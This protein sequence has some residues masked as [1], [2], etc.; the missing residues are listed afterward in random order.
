V[1][2]SGL[3]RS[4]RSA[5]FCARLFICISAVGCAPASSTSAAAVACAPPP[6]YSEPSETRSRAQEI[7]PVSLRVPRPAQAP[8]ATEV[9][10]GDVRFG[11][12]RRGFFSVNPISEGFKLVFPSGQNASFTLR[13][14][15]VPVNAI[16]CENISG[17]SEIEITVR[18]S[19]EFW[20]GHDCSDFTEVKVDGERLYV[21][22]DKKGRSLTGTTQA[23]GLRSGERFAG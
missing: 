4:R 18:K 16:R 23:I 11:G 15:A 17:T 2:H 1:A 14:R 21:Y 22:R 20:T 5:A 3:S 7:R 13:V 9:A 12:I 19:L 6:S 10:S 8:A